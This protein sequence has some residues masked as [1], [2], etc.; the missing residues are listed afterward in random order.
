MAVEIRKLGEAAGAEVLGLDMFEPWDAATRDVVY[1]A[2]LD[3]LVLVFRD[4]VLT[5]PEFMAFSRNFG[6]LQPHVAK[7]YRHPEAEDIVMMTNVDKQGKFDEV[8]ANRGVGW[9]SDLSYDQVPANGTL[10]HAVELPDRGGDTWFCNLYQAYETMPAA[11]KRRITG[12]MALFRYGGRYGQSTEHLLPK[13]KAK[14]DVIHPVVRLH[15]E[16]GRPAVYVNPYH[17]VRIIGMTRAESDALLDE[18][19]AWCDQADFQWHHAW[20]LGDTIIWENRSAV[21]SGKLDYPLDQR[22]I[23]MRATVRGTNTLAEARLPAG[24]TDLAA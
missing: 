1:K 4:Q 16:T 2:Y 15:P 10:L 5:A 20:R 17:T 18:I 23:F 19:F 22:R 9:H 8:G 3:N 21:H 11:L 7:K 14:P 6:A 13:D 12:R 24:D